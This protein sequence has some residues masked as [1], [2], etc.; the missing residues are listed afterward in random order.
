MCEISA[1]RVCVCVHMFRNHLI[2]MEMFNI[3][4]AYQFSAPDSQYVYDIECWYQPSTGSQTTTCE[5]VGLGTLLIVCILH[6]YMMSSA[7]LTL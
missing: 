6:H 7:S 5:V 2:R 1:N 3:A 4:H